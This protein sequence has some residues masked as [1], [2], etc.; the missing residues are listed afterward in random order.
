MRHNKQA[1]RVLFIDRDEAHFQKGFYVIQVT[2]VR[3]V[4]PDGDCALVWEESVGERSGHACKC[5]V[6]VACCPVQR[7]SVSKETKI[8]AVT[9]EVGLSELLPIRGSL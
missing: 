1:H 2:L 7:A 5:V 9:Y 8:H 6:P 3:I 4:H